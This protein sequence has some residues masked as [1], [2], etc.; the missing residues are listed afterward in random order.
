MTLR[1]LSVALLALVLCVAPS[2]WAQQ[3]GADDVQKEL[4]ALRRTVRAMQKELQELRALVQARPP[5]APTAAPAI[6]AEIDL[7]DNPSRG[8]RTAPITLVEF[9]DYQCPFCARHVRDTAALIEKQYVAT[10]KVRHVFL[11]YP[12][13]SLHPLAFKAAEAAFCAGEQGKYWEMHDRLFAN[14]QALEPWEAH[15]SAVGLGCQRRAQGHGRGAQTGRH[16]HAVV[17]PGLHRSEDVA[18][19]DRGAPGRRAVDHRV[20]CPDRQ[21]ACR[22]TEAG[23]GPEVGR[24][25]PTPP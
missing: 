4:A 19:E 14:Q 3:A 5:A 16:R 7:R 21:A 6:N 22:G 24:G 15:T 1:L 9:S 20:Q 17:L 11:D 2:A 10:G 23:R 25:V 8:E 18:G 13:D 12:I